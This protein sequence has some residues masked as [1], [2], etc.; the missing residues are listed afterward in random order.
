MIGKQLYICDAE[1]VYLKRLASYLNR[2]S[3]FLWRIK[4]YTRLEDCVRERPETLLVSGKALAEYGE[5]LNI[6]GCRILFLEDGNYLPG[7]IP[8]IKKY[9][10]A[11]KLYEELLEILGDEVERDTEIIA[12]YDPAYGVSAERDAIEIAET[13]QERGETLLILMTEFP[14]VLFGERAGESLSEWFYYQRQRREGK[15]KLADFVYREGDID[16]VRGFRAVYDMQETEL[17]DWRAFFTDELY[18]SRYGT[19]IFV[20]DRLPPYIE[21]MLWCDAV[22]VR[23]GKD[24]YEERRRQAFE[25]MAGYM[26]VNELLEKMMTN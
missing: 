21:L 9:Q 17:A 10:S 15:K 26:G 25:K 24:G 14:A 13:K 4:T 23:W 3:G 1:P 16:Y 2:H 18:K 12:V 19:V 6:P 20:F 22:Y 5:A 8:S 11:R 7:N